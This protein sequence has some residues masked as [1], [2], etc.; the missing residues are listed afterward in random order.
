MTTTWHPDTCKCIIDDSHNITISVF[1]KR[2]KIHQASTVQQVLD[3]N[4]IFGVIHYNIPKVAWHKIKE[5][6]RTEEAMTGIETAIL[7]RYDQMIQ[8]KRN[9][10]YRT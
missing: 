4:H 1:V 2:C 3:H 8:D 6:L 7:E 5:K 10:K 9:E